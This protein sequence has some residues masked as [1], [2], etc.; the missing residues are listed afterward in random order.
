[1]YILF[2]TVE[3]VG[4]EKEIEISDDITDYEWREKTILLRWEKKERK[5]DYLKTK[6][7]LSV[8]NF[9]S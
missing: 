7:K 8:K 2:S 1:M 4:K 9:K 5:K 6:R 3:T